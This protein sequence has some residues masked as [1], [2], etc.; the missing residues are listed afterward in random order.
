[1]VGKSGIEGTEERS[2]RDSLPQKKKSFIFL[3]E[4]K[5]GTMYFRNVST[6]VPPWLTRDYGKHSHR[7]LHLFLFKFRVRN[8]FVFSLVPTLLKIKQPKQ[9]LGFNCLFVLGHFCSKGTSCKNDG[10][11]LK[12]HYI[13]CTNRSSLTYVFFPR[14]T[15]CFTKTVTCRRAFNLSFLPFSMYQKIPPFYR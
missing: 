12:Q 9:L 7:I 14:V 2:Q 13:L 11:P 15:M 8:S 4:G 10:P 1:M 3:P 6:M 5:Y